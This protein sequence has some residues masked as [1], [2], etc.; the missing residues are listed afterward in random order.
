M[1][2]RASNVYCA[3]K[4]AT[5][6]ESKLDQV[7]QVKISLTSTPRSLARIADFSVR[8]TPEGDLKATLASGVLCWVPLLL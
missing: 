1:F 6:E 4:L 7:K 3:Q 8:E 2:T 5:E